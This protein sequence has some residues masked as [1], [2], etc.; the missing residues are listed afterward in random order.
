MSNSKRVS[1]KWN[2]SALVERMKQGKQFVIRVIDDSGIDTLFFD[3]SGLR[4]AAQKF[5]CLKISGA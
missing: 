4:D 3:L 1:S 5:D 2:Q